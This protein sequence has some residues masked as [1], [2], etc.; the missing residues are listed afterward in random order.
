MAKPNESNKSRYDALVLAVASG[1]SVAKWC[2]STRTPRKT[3]DDWM[4]EP[5]FRAAVEGIRQQ[6]RDEGIGVLTAAMREAAEGM[7]FLSKKSTSDQV[8]LSAQRA[9]LD[10]GSFETVQQRLKE[11]E[12]FRAKIERRTRKT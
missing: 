5:E 2:R 9:I 6:C 11:L 4:R 12:E 1:V 8:K 10:V 7:V 3:V